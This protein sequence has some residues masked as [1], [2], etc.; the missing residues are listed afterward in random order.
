MQIMQISSLI[1]HNT[2]MYEVESDFMGKIA[3]SSVMKQ[4]IG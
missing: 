4:M 3:L 2:K 1:M